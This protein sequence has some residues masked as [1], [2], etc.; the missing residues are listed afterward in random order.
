[1]IV[2][3]SGAT[4]VTRRYH[5][6]PHLGWLLTPRNKNNVQQVIAA[7]VPWAADN[8][9]FQRLD[10]MAYRRMLKRIAGAADHTRL[11]F[12]TVPDVLCDAPATRRR[13]YLWAP[14]LRYYQLPMAFVAQDGQEETSVPWGCIVAVFIGGSTAW[15]ESVHAGR[16]I[17]AAKQREKWV[18]VGR[19][20]TLRRAR[21]MD[22]LGADSID[23]TAFSKFSDTYLPQMLKH[24]TVQQRGMLEALC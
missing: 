1:M 11:L 4:A 17:H 19:V 6:H 5:G 21:L 10:A 9:C 16:L 20:N 14:V 18:H 15:K 12:V 22:A 2:L 24:L 3:V 8:D 7:R 13:F 23:G